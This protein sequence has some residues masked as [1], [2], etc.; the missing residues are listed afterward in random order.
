MQWWNTGIL[1]YWLEPHDCCIWIKTF[2][3]NC[4]DLSMDIFI[5]SS[6]YDP[7]MAITAFQ[8]QWACLF[9]LKRKIARY[10]TRHYIKGDGVLP[11]GAQALPR[12]PEAGREIF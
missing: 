5:G 1:E 8:S 9:D 2:G 3:I 12:G 4:Y 7:I 11:C 6:N 10:L